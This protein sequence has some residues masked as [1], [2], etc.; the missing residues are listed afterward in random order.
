[1]FGFVFSLY[2]Y[3][4]G[5]LVKMKGWEGIEGEGGGGWH[6]L[7]AWVGGVVVSQAWVRAKVKFVYFFGL[8]LKIVRVE[9]G[10]GG[11]VVGGKSVDGSK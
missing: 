10:G 6:C 1:M 3:S 4:D 9:R 8:G 5:E 11:G 7:G 2:L